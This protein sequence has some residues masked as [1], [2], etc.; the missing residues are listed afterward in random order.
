MLFFYLREVAQMNAF[1]LGSVHAANQVLV[2]F[3][4]HERNH[5]SG[6]LTEGNQTGVKCHVSV[7][8]ILLHALCPETLS[9]SSYIPVAQIVHK[10]LKGSCGFGNFVI[11]EVVI[12]LAHYG[13]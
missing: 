2:D 5:G 10:F 9:A 13:V 7:N 6:C 12:H 1:R 8:L 3:F 4:G 11:A